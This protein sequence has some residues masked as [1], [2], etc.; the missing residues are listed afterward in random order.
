MPIL[1]SG[2]TQTGPSARTLVRVASP[3]VER[4][5]TLGEV[6]L[7]ADALGVDRLDAVAALL[8]TLHE[9]VESDA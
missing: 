3:D 5:L 2:I 9:H 7:I 4:D 8:R 1:H 6:D